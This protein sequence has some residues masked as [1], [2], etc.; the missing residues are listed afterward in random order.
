MFNIK[1]K[2]EQEVSELTL[3]HKDLIQR[4]SVVY[5]FLEEGPSNRSKRSFFS[6]IFGRKRA[7]RTQGKIDEMNRF[8]NSKFRD[9]ENIK[10][11]QN[12]IKANIEATQ[13]NIKMTININ[14]KNI[15]GLFKRIEDFNIIKQNLQNNV[16]KVE[17]KLIYHSLK[18]DALDILAKVR[19]LQQW[20]IDLSK[21]SIHPEIAAPEEIT[22]SMQRVILNDKRFLAPPTFTNFYDIS[23]TITGFAFSL[24]KSRTILV[25][26]LIPIYQKEKLN[27]FEVINVPTIRNDKVLKISNIREKFCVINE[28]QDQYY[29]MR[30]SQNFMKGRNFYFNTDDTSFDLIPTSENSKTSCIINIF[31]DRSLNNCKY[32]EIV[33]N[34]EVTQKIDSN[35]Y[36]FAIREKTHI[37]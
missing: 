1:F 24:K 25:N 12:T 22:D 30:N 13:N 34:I 18:M 4:L 20:M 2:C 32:K 8:M 27:L 21:N 14:E 17:M 6:K 28:A 11:H 26:F 19:D 7:K 36:L 31:K 3:Y 5:D 15:Q 16:N 33:Q 37:R 10:A 9:I 29:C 35:K 23:E